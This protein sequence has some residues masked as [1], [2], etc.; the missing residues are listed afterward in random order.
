[1]L[2]KSLKYLPKVFFLSEIFFGEIKRVF[3][4]SLI[5]P[6]FSSDNELETEKRVSLVELLSLD[7]YDRN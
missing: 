7:T 3:L 1:M 6:D 4:T 5:G 2:V